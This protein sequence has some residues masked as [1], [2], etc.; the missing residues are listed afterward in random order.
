MRALRTE[1]STGGIVH[2]AN[3]QH[4]EISVIIRIT[5]G[6]NSA[7]TT[8]CDIIVISAS[9]LGTHHRDNFLC[10]DATMT[11][12]QMTHVKAFSHIDHCDIWYSNTLH[13]EI[14]SQW[15][16][17]TFSEILLNPAFST[18]REEAR[19]YRWYLHRFV[20][21]IQGV[22]ACSFSPRRLRPP[23]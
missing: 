21:D 22:W 15:C 18:D 19:R 20:P 5:R 9:P 14:V 8:R 2:P 13:A 1:F 3:E 7:A 11:D 4:K 6:P 16:V 12:C 10:I 17:T 23:S